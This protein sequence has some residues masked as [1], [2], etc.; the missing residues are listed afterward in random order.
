MIEQY[1]PCMLLFKSPYTKVYFINHI[2]EGIS[3][4]F[5]RFAFILSLLLSTLQA[6]H[7]FLAPDG[8][9]SNQ[10]SKQKPFFSIKK[11]L[12]A[13]KAGDTL[14]IREGTY[15]LGIIIDI[16]GEE[17]APIMI[18]AYAKEKVLFLGNN[19][20]KNNDIR[21]RGDWIIIKNIEISH[22]YNGLVIEKKASH[23]IVTNVSSHHNHFSGFMI[24]RGAAYNTIIN[25]NAYDNFDKGGSLGDGGNA[26]GFGTGSRI[27]EKQFIGKGNR[28]INCKSWHNSDDGFDFWKSGNAV[29]VINCDAY[30]NGYAKGDGNGFKLGP[31]NPLFSHDN[32]LVINSKAWNNRQNGF[33]YNDNKE[34]ITLFNNIAYNNKVNYK[35]LQYAKHILI[36]N[37]SI[38]SHQENKLSPNIIDINNQ[39]HLKA[40][41][42]LI[43]LNK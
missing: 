39:W 18:S 40:K 3:M 33:D 32:H 11:S 21:L 24:T 1:R 34:A 22:S 12:K 9:D 5:L 41:K 35:F 10:G 7:Y 13:L 36:N 15:P 29:T 30:D 38:L 6:K 8:N 2:L 43:F 42:N 4:F 26:D 14:F 20:P 27:G 16:K 37:K 19:S 28:F 25:C 31:N 17:N 23:N